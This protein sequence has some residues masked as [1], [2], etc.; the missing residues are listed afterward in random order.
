MRRRKDILDPK[1][2]RARQL[3]ER[4]RAGRR[5]RGPLA[6][7]LWQSAIALAG[8][9]GAYRISR[10]LRVNYERLRS[11]LE[12]ACP[13]CPSGGAA[14]GGEFSVILGAM[15]SEAPAMLGALPAASP[16]IIGSMAI[17]TDRTFR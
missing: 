9:H 5:K 10:E 15:W 13:S 8:R 17:P 12:A 6:D 2:E 14:E 3:F 11:R 16:A 1:L 4:W 7:D